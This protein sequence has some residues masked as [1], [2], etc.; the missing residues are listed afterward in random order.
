M[1]AAEKDVTKFLGIPIDG[2]KTD[3]INKLLAK[4]F[5]IRD[6]DDD[7]LE[8]EFNGK[9]VILYVVANHDKV[10]R[11]IVKEKQYSNSADIKI[12][13]N[14]LCRQFENNPKYISPDSYIIPDEERIEYQIRNKRYEAGYFQIVDIENEEL[15]Q[16][17]QESIINE[18]LTKYTTDEL[19][20]PTDEISAEIE[21]IKTKNALDL[22]TKKSVWFMIDK[23][24][25]ILSLDRK[26]YTL[27]I[28]YDNEY[29][30]ANGE[31]L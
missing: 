11:I 29:N 16:E 6:A 12:R 5:I 26:D 8:G 14:N 3:M 24:N 19:E 27:M 21:K 28:F 13:F 4:G 31:D 18:L 25:N 17:L 7:S 15:I 1:Q 20:N 10:Y 23:S 9:D 22:L 2:T 30:K